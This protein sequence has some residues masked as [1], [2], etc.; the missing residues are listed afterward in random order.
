MVLT[1]RED[2]TKQGF[3]KILWRKLCLRGSLLL[4]LI[5]ENLFSL[6]GG[7]GRR[8]VDGVGVGALLSLSWIRRDVGRGGRLFEAMRLLTF[9]AF[10]IGAYSRWALLRGWAL[11]RI[12]TVYYYCV[13]TNLNLKRATVEPVFVLIVKVTFLVRRLNKSSSTLFQ[14]LINVTALKFF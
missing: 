7:G 9:S 12:N 3:C 5:Q 2:V 11:I 1:K 4:E 14:S 8:K 10:R 13:C 6:G